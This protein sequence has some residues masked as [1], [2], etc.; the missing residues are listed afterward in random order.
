MNMFKLKQNF[1]FPQSHDTSDLSENL[2]S[3]AHQAQFI[4]YKRSV[5]TTT[6]TTTTT[7]TKNKHKPKHK[8]ATLTTTKPIL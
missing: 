2:I 3:N 8:Q 6:T 4:G 1:T 5:N 7:T